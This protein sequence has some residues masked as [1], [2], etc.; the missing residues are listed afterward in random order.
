MAKNAESFDR[1]TAYIGRQD[2]DGEGGGG[3]DVVQVEVV[4]QWR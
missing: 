1:R 4:V 3:S 2:R